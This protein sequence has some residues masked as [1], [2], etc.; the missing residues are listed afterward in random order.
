MPLVAW[1]V[2]IYIYICACEIAPAILTM[3]NM[4]H[5][6]DVDVLIAPSGTRLIPCHQW[7]RDCRGVGI[8]VLLIPCMIWILADMAPIEA[9]KQTDHTWSHVRQRWCLFGHITV[10]VQQQLIEASPL[11]CF[12]HPG[13]FTDHF[14]HLPHSWDTCRAC[15]QTLAVPNE[16][17]PRTTM[18]WLFPSI[19]IL[20]VL[21]RSNQAEI[22]QSARVNVDMD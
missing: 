19:V 10:G 18:I 11:F 16:D 21:I 7:R 4:A 15:V 9:D 12:P 6:F 20:N 3:T 14:A 13:L 2:Y 5:V 17:K 8:L 1:L 22:W